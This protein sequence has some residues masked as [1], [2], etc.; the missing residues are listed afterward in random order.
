MDRLNPFDL[1]LTP[2]PV[3]PATVRDFALGAVEQ[4]FITQNMVMVTPNPA[5]AD[6]ANRRLRRCLLVA[7]KHYPSSD[8]LYRDIIQH[9]ARATVLPEMAKMLSVRPEILEHHYADI[10]GGFVHTLMAMVRLSGLASACRNAHE[11]K[12]PNRDA[13]AGLPWGAVLTEEKK[14]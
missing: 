6:L 5:Q 2:R 12:F 1:D 14:G 13:E 7:G 4:A 10:I 8:K 3:T 11:E 9:P